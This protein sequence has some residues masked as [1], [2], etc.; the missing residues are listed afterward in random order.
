[1]G[2]VLL[3]FSVVLGLGAAVWAVLAAN[4][5]QKTYGTA[6]LST[7]LYYQIFVAVFGLYGIAGQGIVKKILTARGSPFQTT[8]TVWHLFS[9]LGAPFLILAWYMFLRFSREISDETPGRGFT[10]GFFLA[11]FAI[12]VAYGAGLGA[13]NYT[14]AADQAFAT[15]SISVKVLFAVLDAAVVAAAVPHLLSAAAKM[16]DAAKGSAVRAFAWLAAAAW[17]ARLLTFLAS[18]RGGM[19]FSLYVLVFFAA[20]VPPLLAWRSYLLGHVPGPL[21][22]ASASV[23]DMKTFSREFAISRREEEVIRQVLEGKTNKEASE[24]LYI[25]VQTVKDHLYR[26]FQKTGV[27]NRVQLINLVQA[28]GQAA[29][30][31]PVD[32]HADREG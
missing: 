7:L 32:E 17:L 20:A 9:F 27:R 18:G 12:Y 26:V 14:K 13:L 25:S 19:L 24:A 3:V 31:A 28:R 8:E 16:R 15:F 21:E 30:A 29:G 11:A 1:M 22:T 2:N 10:L 4:D 23:V 6:S 5:L